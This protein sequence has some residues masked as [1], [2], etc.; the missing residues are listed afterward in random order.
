LNKALSAEKTTDMG[1]PAD[2]GAKLRIGGSYQSDLTNAGIHRMS[3]LHNVALT[4]DEITK[5]A[6]QWTAWAKAVGLT[7]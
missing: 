1:N 7:I 6:T 3:A 4:D 5:A 2:L